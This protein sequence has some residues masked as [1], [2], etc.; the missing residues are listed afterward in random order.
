MVQNR[1]A[2]VNS[3]FYWRSNF[4]KVLGLVFLSFL[5]IFVFFYE[6]GI[7]GS[8]QDQL[9]VNEKKNVE[10]KFHIRRC[11]TTNRTLTLL[12]GPLL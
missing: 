3:L 5:N 8:N 4:L 1:S 12:K 2:S 7:K 10:N 11:V 6:E 9:E